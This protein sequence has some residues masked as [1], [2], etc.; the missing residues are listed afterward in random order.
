VWSLLIAPA[1]VVA[2]VLALRGVVPHPAAVLAALHTATAGWVAVAAAS[3]A[4]SMDMFARQQRRL[5]G[6]F[7]VAISLPRAEALTYARSALSVSMPAGAVVSAGFAYRQY[8]S[9]GA[10]H[11]VATDVTILSG[12]L[13]MAGLAALYAVWTGAVVVAGP[14]RAH[15]SVAIGVVAALGGGW[16]LARHRSGRSRHLAATASHEQPSAVRRAQARVAARWPR[17]G[18]ALAPVADALEAAAA[19]R[20]RDLVVALGYA[21][22]NWVADLGCLIAVGHAFGLGLSVAQFAGAYLAV[23][24]I[25]QL[26]LT[27]GGIGVIEASLLVALVAAGAPHVA[28]AAVVLVYRVLSCWVIVPTGLAAWAG[29]LSARPRTHRPRSHR[30]A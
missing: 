30:P 20:R 6:A 12:V 17:A 29:L 2:A 15:P 19:A 26:P 14:V 11:R 16:A 13:S 24:I 4:L 10:S 27:P 18:R 21:A 25:R 28:A 23:Q 1:G 22:A 9:R 8:Q 3:E 7:G 5:L